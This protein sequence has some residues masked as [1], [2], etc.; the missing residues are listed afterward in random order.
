MLAISQICTSSWRDSP[1]IW[2]CRF[3][4]I[5][6]HEFRSESLHDCNFFHI[7]NRIDLAKV[8]AKRRS[9]ARWKFWTLS[10]PDFSM[11]KCRGIKLRAP[12]ISRWYKR[13]WRKSWPNWHYQRESYTGICTFRGLAA[14]VL[15]SISRYREKFL[16]L[17]DLFNKSQK[18]LEEEAFAYLQHIRQIEL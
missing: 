10:L 12:M 9:Y 14:P 8:I 13:I 1:W 16:L 18:E 4:P 7:N 6:N 11:Q 15:G 2:H 3:A 17:E 5:Q